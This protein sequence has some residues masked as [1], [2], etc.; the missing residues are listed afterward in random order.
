MYNFA[1]F[2]INSASVGAE[3]MMTNLLTVRSSVTLNGQPG[4]RATCKYKKMYLVLL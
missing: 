3:L 4:G 1:S 2:M